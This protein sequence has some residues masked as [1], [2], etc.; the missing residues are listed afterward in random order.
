MTEGLSTT[1]ID[2]HHDHEECSKS[3]RGLGPV[4]LAFAASAMAAVG[5]GLLTRPHLVPWYA[6]LVKP[7]YTP[8][9]WAFPVAWN[10]LYI[11]MAFAVLSYWQHPEKKPAVIWLYFLQLVLNLVW[12]Y[13]FFT[14]H[15]P[16]AGLICLSL[17]WLLMV[18]VFKG[19]WTTHRFSG[20][21]FLPYCLWITY[22]WAL[23]A[24]LYWLNR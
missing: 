15:S 3:D 19:F 16:L 2:T 1:T 24:G 18:P 11:L 20:W 21:L 9:N 12:S 13:A 23:N 17:M 7:W 10:T 5:G 4:I 6:S 8:P 22:A 14:L